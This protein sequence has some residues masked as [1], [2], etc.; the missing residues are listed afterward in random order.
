M[1]PAKFILSKKVL[2]DQVKKLKDLGLNISYSY[3]TNRIV[4]DVLQE[5]DKDISYSL[6]LKQE[7]NMIKDKS[8][9]WFFTQ[10]ENKETLLEIL[11][12]NV[13][14][15]VIDNEIDL[16]NIIDIIQDKNI[17]INISLR[18]KFQ[19][20]RVGSGKYFVYGMSSK[21]INE[22]IEKLK[23]NLHVEKLGV[24]IHRKS[25][26]TSEWEIIEELKDSL[27]KSSLE[28]IN[29]INLGGGLPS[30]Y[31]SLNKKAFQYIFDKIKESVEWLKQQNI[32]IFIEPGR[33]L[34]A[35]CIKLITEVIQK[36]E[37]ILIIN[38]SLY[39]C[40][41]DTLLT[42]T[43]MLI[44]GELEAPLGVSQS[45]ELRDKGDSYLIKGNSPTRDDIFRY[46]TYLEN[47]NVGDKIVF[48]NAGAYT[49]STDFCG[50]EKL[51]TEIVEDFL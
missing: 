3:K 30:M 44:Q 19:E 35:P 43:K 6:H 7:I 17:K 50:Y 40:A 28:R 36:Q 1:E 32:D 21:K 2:L 29:F 4:G 16:E 10:A 15:F 5:L 13:Q 48:L 51:N 31:R 42:N 26:N 20:H 23:N 24:H 27:S 33:F 41:L 25:Q 22:L 37:R 38:T 9:V 49:Y 11:N 8:K 18:M 12:E 46:K 39:N 14:N 34:A 47:I 45:T